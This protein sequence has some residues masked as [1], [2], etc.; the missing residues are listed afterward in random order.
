MIRNVFVSMVLCSILTACAGTQTQLPVISIPTETQ[1][2]PTPELG[3]A[4]SALTESVEI[5]ERLHGWLL[6][7]CGPALTAAVLIERGN[8]I[9]PVLF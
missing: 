5:S 7:F 1:L 4:T 9:L 3:S 2:L 6:Q 8:L